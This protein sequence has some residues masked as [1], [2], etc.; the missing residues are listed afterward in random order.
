MTCMCRSTK[1][2]VRRNSLVL[3]L[4]PVWEHSLRT[5]R[6]PYKESILMCMWHVLEIN[7]K[8]SMFVFGP[9]ISCTEYWE[10]ILH[11]NLNVW[12]SE[13][14]LLTEQSYWELSHSLAETEKI[15]IYLWLRTKTPKSDHQISNY[16]FDRKTQNKWPWVSLYFGK[17]KWWP[18]VIIVGLSRNIY[19]I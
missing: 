18:T 19:K 7:F 15:L 1:S 6:T 4:F 10:D 17:W 16:S 9:K 14:F 8:I 3:M 5:I 11:Y 13:G 12:D 2:S